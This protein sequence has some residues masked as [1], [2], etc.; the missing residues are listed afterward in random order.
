MMLAFKSC[1]WSLVAGFGLTV[2]GVGV[3]VVFA[4]QVSVIGFVPVVAHCARAPS[5]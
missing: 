4:A 3:V 1:L 2:L 5:G